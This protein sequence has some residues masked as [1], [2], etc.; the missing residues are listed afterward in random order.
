MAPAGCLPCSRSITAPSRKVHPRRRMK[1]MRWEMPQ[2][3]KKRTRWPHEACIAPVYRARFQRPP[4]NQN[5]PIVLCTA[6]RTCPLMRAGFEGAL[7]HRAA[8]GATLRL[9]AAGCA[10]ARRPRRW[11]FAACTSRHEGPFTD[12]PPG[13]A[14]ELPRHALTTR[15]TCW[16]QGT[17][18]PC[19]WRLALPAS[20]RKPVKPARG[21]TESA[22]SPFGRGRPV[23]P[24]LVV[25][26]GEG[27][28]APWAS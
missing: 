27:A 3:W 23:R 1:R 7:P 2:R 10:K 14:M 21:E 22:T 12:T 24:W 26:P 6:Q 13:L 15:A 11:R 16:R 17:F 28:A 25:N 9:A 20:G 4:Q 19:L 8:C 5:R 18:L